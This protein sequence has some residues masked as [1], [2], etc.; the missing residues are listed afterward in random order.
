VSDLL[1]SVIAAH[2][3]ISRWREVRTVTTRLRSWGQTWAHKGNPSLLSNGV[4]AEAA[5]ARQAVR[6][7]PFA[8]A[9]RSGFYTPDRVRVE[10][11]DGTILEDR[12]HPRDAFAGHTVE[13][14]WDQLHCLYFAGY[15]LWT[16]F[17]LPFLAA[18]PDIDVEEIEP[19]QE[20]PGTKWRRLRLVFPPHIATH[21][22]VQDLYI[23]ENGLIVRHDY[24]PDVIASAP[25]AH[26]LYD[27]ADHDGIV[28][29][30]LRKV[31]SRNAD[32]RP[33]PLNDPEGLLIGIEF[34]GNYTL[35]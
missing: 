8:D 17:N 23:D 24:A 18:R 1:D 12:R 30:S 35:T 26:Y 14:P 11:T 9:D 34:A 5:T 6:I 2:G 16:Y 25:T 32:N 7:H 10:S 15:A 28:F 33:G 22:S 19:W 20:A 21:N 29:P 13:S 27:Y 4:T 3:G 31:A